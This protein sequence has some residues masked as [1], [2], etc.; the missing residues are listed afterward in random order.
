[1]GKKEKNEEKN[2]A[3]KMKGNLRIWEGG[4]GAMISSSYSDQL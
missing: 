1:L 2:K 4:G 3:D